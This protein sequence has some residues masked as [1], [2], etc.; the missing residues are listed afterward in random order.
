MSAAPRPYRCPSRWLGTKGS[1]RQRSSGPVGTTSVWPAKA[2]V[3]PARL[4]R[5][6]AN[7]LVTRKSA[8]PKTCVSQQETGRLQPLTEQ[9]LAAAVLG[10]DAAPGDQR[11]GQAQRVH[12]A[13]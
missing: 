3:G 10:R 2:S 4:P 13:P 1:L 5:R 9:R 8:G 11:L 7:R 6:S 12:R